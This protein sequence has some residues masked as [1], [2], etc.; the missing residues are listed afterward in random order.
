MASSSSSANG[1]RATAEMRIHAPGGESFQGGDSVSQTPLMRHQVVVHAAEAAAGAVGGSGRAHFVPLSRF[2][3]ACYSVGHVL[4]DMTAACWFSY[5][6]LYLEE[7]EKLSGAEAGAVLFAGQV[8]DAIATPIVGLLSDKSKGIP[9]LG[10]GRRKL[11]NAGGVAIVVLCFLGVF[12]FCFACSIVTGRDPTA[13]EKTIS[14]SVFAALFNV[15]WASVQV[16]HMAMVPELTYDD[17]ERVVLNSARYAFTILSNLAVFV[18]MLAI[19]GVGGADGGSADAGDPGGAKAADPAIYQ[20][21]AI[22][23][24]G[25]GGA[26]SAVFLLG[27]KEKV[28]EPANKPGAG[29][30]YASIAEEEE[31]EG[32]GEGE[33]EDE[34]DGKVGVGGLLPRPA[35]S[36]AAPL[37]MMSLND[38]RPAVMTWRDW[39]RFPQF[40]QVA[41]IYALTRL[42]TNVSQ[43]YLPFFVTQTLQMNQAAIASTPM[44]LYIAQL[45]ATIAMRRL[46]ARL[47]R[48]RTMA[49]GALAFVAASALMML[50]QPS[51]SGGM[52]F[53]VLVLGVGCAIVMV[54]SVSFEA[55]LVGANTES[56]AFVYGACSFADKLF[57][58]AAILAVQTAGDG[59]RDPGLRGNFVRYVNGLIPMCAV[60]LAALFAWTLTLKKGQAALSVAAAAAAAGEEG[61]DGADG[62]ATSA[63]AE[64]RSR[65]PSGSRAGRQERRLSGASPMRRLSEGTEKTSLLASDTGGY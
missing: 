58:G 51:S 22:I 63:A 34:G 23:V 31:G 20:R 41:A 65:R 7:A 45:G 62:D 26:C 32:E 18:A 55:D 13:A 10:L 15:G 47:G 46:S 1:G 53:A 21:L 6:L 30:A 3:A 49:A 9:S 12:G 37:R 60:I 57:N 42:A 38:A 54:I 50:L 24:L 4:N 48:K 19:V 44:L 14:Y 11:F 59:I 16:S 40:Y 2:T 56:G 43:V 61:A 35:A 25:V 52:Y 5:L 27:T 39:L 8:A 36:A 28:V 33:G 64:P 29:G 17:S